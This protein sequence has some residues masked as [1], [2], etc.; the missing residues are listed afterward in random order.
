MYQYTSAAVQTLVNEGITKGKML[1]NVVVL[2][3]IDLDD[4]ML[5]IYDEV[6]IKRQPQHGYYMC[7]IGHVQGFFAS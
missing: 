1:K 5:E 6:I 2:D 3:V 4:V 7:D